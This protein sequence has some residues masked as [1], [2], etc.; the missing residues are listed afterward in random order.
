MGQRL[1]SAL[2]E[3]SDPLV[4]AAWRGNSALLRQAK[5]DAVYALAFLGCAFVFATLYALLGAYRSSLITLWT[6]LP[7]LL[8]LVALERANSPAVCGHLLC[9][10]GWATLTAIGIVT[11][12]W[13]GIP[14]MLWFT[15]LP[16]VAVT[17][18]GRW[19]GLLWTAVSLATVSAFAVAQTLGVVFPQELTSTGQR[20]VGYALV[21]GL[22]L[23]Q[24]IA[25][26]I[27]IGIEQRA[28][29]SLH[30]TRRKLAKARNEL[31]ELQAGFG[32]S[33][34][35]WERLKR[36]KAALEYFVRRRFG[37]VDLNHPGLALA[38]DASA[39]LSDSDGEHDAINAP[40][41]SQR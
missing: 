28:L 23:Y 34:K 40:E 18:A 13:T 29:G 17:T 5:C 9:A 19:A 37:A 38:A 7:I 24:L 26:W 39:A 15:G 20:V 16:V 6:V 14:P 2:N 12:G 32:F 4:P 11:G 10:G 25:V 8:S 33:I 22:L 36:E 21:A 41:P 3:L 27:R 1:A 35:D 30:R 31:Q